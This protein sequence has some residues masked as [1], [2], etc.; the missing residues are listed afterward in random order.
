VPIPVPFLDVFGKVGLAQWTPSGGTSFS[1][2]GG[3][4]SLSDNGTQFAWGV[5]TQ[6][7]VGNFG[8][9]LEYESSRIPST[10]GANVISLTVFL[11]PH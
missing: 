1:L 5:G 4:S 8:A 10:N 6:V 3:F 7:H 9:R 11:N 2:P